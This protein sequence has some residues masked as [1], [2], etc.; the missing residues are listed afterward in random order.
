MKI[1]TDMIVG[2]GLVA[3]LLA[4]IFLGGSTELPQNIASG[5]VGYL[6]RTALAETE[7]S[8]GELEDRTNGIN[9][10]K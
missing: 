5:L 9:Q 4:A 6:G 10:Q 7:R 1:T 2:T 3:A 8:N